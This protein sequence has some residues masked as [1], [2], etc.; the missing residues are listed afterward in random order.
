MIYKESDL[1]N[2]LDL[3]RLDEGYNVSI[4]MIPM[5]ESAR[6]GENL[7]SLEESIK[8]MNETDTEIADYVKHVCES[9][10]ID[11]RSLAFTVDP[12]SVYLDEDCYTAMKTLMEADFNVYLNDNN[13]TE[14]YKIISSTINEC[15]ETGSLDTLDTLSEGLFN[16][17]K[18]GVKSGTINGVLQGI[19]SAG[20]ATVDDVTRG[21]KRGLHNGIVN[22]VD[23]N[24]FRKLDTQKTLKNGNVI[25][26]KNGAVHDFLRKHGVQNDM[27]HGVANHVVNGMRSGAIDGLLTRGEQLLGY[28]SNKPVNFQGIVN[29]IQSKLSGLSAKM[30]STQDPNQRSFIQKILDKL[31][32]LKN[33]IIAKFKGQSQ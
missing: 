17:I 5:R 18:Q 14:E 22:T 16:N 21:A 8:Y 11:V 1:D 10:H 28:D 32:N 19:G 24:V 6:L 31:T 7:I 2:S 13:D 29:A 30:N 4:S 15:F 9:N 33:K 3:N 12:A 27:A 25:T 26:Q 20:M 23:D